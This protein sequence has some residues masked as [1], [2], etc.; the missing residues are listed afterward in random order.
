MNLIQIKKEDD[1]LLLDDVI[2]RI[3][4]KIANKLKQKQQNKTNCKN[5]RIR[6]KTHIFNHMAK[7][8]RKGDKTS[9]ISKFDLFNIAKK[10]KL[11]CA[12]TGRKLTLNNISPDHIIPKA[13]GG[14]SIPENIQL[15][16]IEANRAKHMMNNNDFINLC[17]DVINFNKTNSNIK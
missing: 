6:S 8:I 2:N 13:R 17:L 3:R 16:T 11:I 12:L 14:Q 5:K 15:V 4:K 9:I 10:Q 7:S 1:L